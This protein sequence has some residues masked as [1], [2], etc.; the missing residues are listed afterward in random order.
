MTKLIQAYET[1]AFDY[2]AAGNR[3]KDAE[4]RLHVKLTPISKANVCPYYGYEIDADGSL[5]LDRDRVYNLLRDAAELKK[6]ADT[7]NGIQL[8]QTHISVS[9]DDPQKE[10]TVGSVGTDAVFV[11]PYL[12][13]SLCVWDQSAVDAIESGRKKQISCGYTYRADMTP[14]IYQG[15]A[16]DGVIRDIVFNHVALVEEGRA[17]PD[18][19]V[20][21]AMPQNI[22]SDKELNMTKKITATD[23]LDKAG[24]DEWEDKDKKEGKDK[25]KG[26]DKAK[27]E[28]E[29]M[30]SEGEDESETENKSE[31]EKEDDLPKPGK[32]KKAKD[33]DDEED[34]DSKGM[35]AA[36]AVAVREIEKKHRALRQAEDL[37]RPLVGTVTSAMDSAESVYEV[38][39]KSQG[40]D[41]SDMPKAGYAAFAKYIV[42]NASATK[43]STQTVAQDS[44][45]VK[46]FETEFPGAARIKV[47]K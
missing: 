46:S 31:D 24:E 43:Q 11:A 18:V 6:G 22:N 17:G 27:D 16:H 42:A 9:A 40:I 38:L 37:V 21:D 32:D 19:M 12:K 29:D 45:A 39:F 28:E 23:E 34:K 26:R 33:E 2:K 13:N 7:C 41:V 36:I 4:G 47:H 1:I 35:D 15:V 5:G 3:T 25:G 30:D 20:V 44:A 8:M 14:G 10:D